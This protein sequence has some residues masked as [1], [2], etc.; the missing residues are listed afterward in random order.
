MKLPVSMT[1]DMFTADFMNIE[2]DCNQFIITTIFILLILAFLIIVSSEKES[3]PHQ[4][5]CTKVDHYL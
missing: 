4:I 3:E 1:P 2:T 5:F